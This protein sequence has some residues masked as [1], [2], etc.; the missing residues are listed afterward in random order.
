MKRGWME[1]LGFLALAALIW[2]PAVRWER[3]QSKPD[4]T[5]W[6]EAVMRAREEVAQGAAALQ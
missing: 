1:R 5:A 6:Q 3:Q 4:H 2:I